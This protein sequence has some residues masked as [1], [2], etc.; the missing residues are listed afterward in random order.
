MCAGSSLQG[1]TGAVSFKAEA[2]TTTSPPPQ[3]GRGIE[4]LVGGRLDL[5]LCLSFLHLL[6]SL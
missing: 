3:G 4:A 2:S 5:R 1:E 6:G